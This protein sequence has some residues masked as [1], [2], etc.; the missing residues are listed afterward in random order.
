[1]PL[2]MVICISA[3]KDIFEDMKRHRSDNV[4][5]NKPVLRSNKK[6]KIFVDDQWKNL[7]VG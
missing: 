6:E 5:N 4:E 7:R 2:M 1:M 3:M